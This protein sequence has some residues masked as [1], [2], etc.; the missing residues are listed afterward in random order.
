VVCGCDTF[1]E[2]DLVVTDC[3]TGQPL[4]GV[5]ASTHL[6][7]GSSEEDHNGTTDMAGRVFLHLNEPDSVTV[8]LSLTKGGYQD[9]TKQFRGEPAK[10]YTVCLQPAQP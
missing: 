8:T 4:Q 3:V 7:D 5:A 9:W 1:F 2:L 6:D 10:P